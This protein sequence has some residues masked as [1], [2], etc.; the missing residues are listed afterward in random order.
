MKTFYVTVNKHP[1][2]GCNLIIELNATTC[3]H[4]PERIDGIWEANHYEEAVNGI[5][6]AVRAVLPTPIV[7]TKPSM[8]KTN[9]SKLFIMEIDDDK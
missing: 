6:N 3:K 9:F 5:M 4:P 8:K 1:E 7:V 2:N